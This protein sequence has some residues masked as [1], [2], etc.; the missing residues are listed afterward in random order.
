MQKLKSHLLRT[1]SLK[2][3][4]LKP[5]D[6]QYIAMQAMLTARNLFLANFYL[7]SPFTS[8]VSKTF[9]PCR[10]TFTWLG[11]CGLCER[12]KSARFVRTFLFCSCVCFCLYGPFSCFLFSKSSQQPSTFSLCSSGLNSA[13]LVLST[14][15]LFMKVSLSPDIIICG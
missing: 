3:L 9:H 11:F 7:S 10:L 2:I 8:I 12:Y 4:P 1:R 13:L 6:G 15:Y 5:E 14:I